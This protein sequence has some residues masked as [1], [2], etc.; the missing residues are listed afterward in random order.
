M[1]TGEAVLQCLILMSGKYFEY[2]T[3]KLDLICH[4]PHTRFLSETGVM[5]PKDT[6]Y[7]LIESLTDC[8]RGGYGGGGGGILEVQ[9][10]HPYMCN[11][12]MDTVAGYGSESQSGSDKELEYGR[13]V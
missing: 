6:N 2:N 8:R 12:N 10:H 5:F 1:Y 4:S 11:R 13:G 3:S 9:I 7:I